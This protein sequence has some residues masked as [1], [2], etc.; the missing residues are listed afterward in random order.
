MRNHRLVSFLQGEVKE[1]SDHK[2]I[3][4]VGCL[5][6][7]GV[8]IND[9]A[10]VIGGIMLGILIPLVTTPTSCALLGCSGM[11][12]PS[13]NHKANCAFRPINLRYLPSN[14]GDKQTCITLD[15]NNY[16]NK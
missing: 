9:H 5:K 8:Y 6:A 15:N 3:Y 14:I 12:S 16:I 11:T 2:P 4:T 13:A 7:V 10:L 1:S